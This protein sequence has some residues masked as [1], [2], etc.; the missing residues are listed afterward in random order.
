MVLLVNKK[1]AQRLDKESATL[2]PST[3]IGHKLKCIKCARQVRGSGDKALMI[4]EPRITSSGA[5]GEIRIST[6]AGWL[7]VGG[8]TPY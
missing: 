2:L 1:E 4:G 5:I 3:G 6:Y 7:I 8:G